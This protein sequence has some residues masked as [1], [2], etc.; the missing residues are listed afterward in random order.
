M[1]GISIIVCCFN[2]EKRLPETLGAILNLKLTDDNIEILIVDNASTDE[3]SKLASME[4]ANSHIPHRIIKEFRPGLNNARQAGVNHAKYEWLLF[5]DDDNWLDPQYLE[6]FHLNINRFPSLSIVGCGISEAVFEIYPEEW[7]FRFKYLCAI[8][9]MGDLQEK[10][11]VCTNLS[12]ESKICGAGMF[13]KKDLLSHY[14]LDNSLKLLGRN[15]KHLS[16]GEDSDIVLYTLK[17]NLTVGQFANLKIRHYIP[18]TRISKKYILNLNQSMSFS[19]A[20]LDYKYHQL[21]KNPNRKQFIFHFIKNLVH[22]NFFICRFDWSAFRGRR[23]AFKF[24]KNNA[25]GNSPYIQ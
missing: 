3:T 20:L 25:R 23:R 22:L 2:S 14:F 19:Y 12:Q 17:N 11:W 9:D 21:L 5:C 16:S 24:L 6:N 10:Y 18:Q 8:F 13:I 7:F 4:L 15:G 1:K